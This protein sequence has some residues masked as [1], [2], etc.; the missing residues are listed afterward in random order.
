MTDLTRIAAAFVTGEDRKMISRRVLAELLA[1]SAV[2]AGCNAQPAAHGPPAGTPSASADS[3]IAPGLKVAA[4]RLRRKGYL[5]VFW[6][7]YRPHAVQVRMFQIVPD[8]RWVA[9][10][11]PYARSHEAGRSVDVTLAYARSRD[12]PAG[13]RVE[14]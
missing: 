9:R 3:S 14:G 2:S 13:Q 7:C 4:D 12:C 10:P 6:D 5:M 8:P 11:G 1:I